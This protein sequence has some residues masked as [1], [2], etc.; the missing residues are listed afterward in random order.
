MPNPNKNIEIKVFASGRKQKTYDSDDEKKIIDTI[1]NQ[2]LPAAKA[3]YHSVKVKV[4][5]KGNQTPEYLLAYMLRKDTYTA[6]VVRIDVNGDYNVKAIKE[7]YDDIDDYDDEDDGIEGASTG[8]YAVYDFV[9]AT[10]CPEIPTAKQAV[11]KLHELATRAGL[12]SK[13]LLGA[14]ATVA[15]YRQYLASG[16]KGFVNIGHGN[17]NEIILHD[18]RLRSAWFL[19]Q[20]GRPVSPAVVY[21]NSCQVFNNPLQPAVMHSGART[22]IGGIVNLLIGASEEVCKCFWTKILKTSSHMGNA[23]QTCERDKYPNIGDHGIS[24]DRGPFRIAR[25]I[26]LRACNDRFVCAI[27]GGGKDLIANRTWI[28]SWETFNLVDLGQGKVA[29]QA[30]NGKYVCAE[31][32]GGR[33]L[34]A[35]RDWIRSW[36][37]FRLKKVVGNRIGLQACNGQYVCAENSGKSHLMANRDWLRS[38]ETFELINLKKVGLKASSGKYVCAVNGGG[39]RLIANRAV[40]KSWETFILT[41]LGGGKVALQACNKQYVCAEDAG[42]KK[43]MANRNWIRGWETFRIVKKSGGKIGFKAYNNKYVRADGAKPLIAK[44]ASMGAK[45]SFKIVEV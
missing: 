45:E 26:G 8:E 15:N 27:D 11:Q 32:G 22:F 43:L 5:R 29:L 9:A 6:E 39:D 24:G 34:R 25:P 13:M 35:N 21:F 20:S 19:S 41:D 17:P 18:G 44:S 16:L 7:D 38:W 40:L 1:R 33:E 31:G 28:R 12:K 37:T 42:K 3:E 30:P 14:D 2:V 23:L 4:K 36:E 10:P